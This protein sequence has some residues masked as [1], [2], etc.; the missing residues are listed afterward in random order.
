MMHENTD[1]KIRLQKLRIKNSQQNRGEAGGFRIVA[2]LEKMK[3]RVTF[4]GIYPKTGAKGKSNENDANVIFLFE[5]FVSEAGKNQLLV[6]SILLEDYLR[7]S[8]IP[9]LPD[10]IVKQDL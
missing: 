4:L 1:N 3:Q 8:G 5:Q 7:P 2:C 10:A 6:F 9:G